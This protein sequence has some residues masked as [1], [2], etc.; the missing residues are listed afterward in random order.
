MKKKTLFWSLLASLIGLLLSVLFLPKVY[1]DGGYFDQI[2]TVLFAGIVLGLVNYFLKPA[3]SLLTAPLKIL[4]LGLFALIL[5]ILI[6]WG[7]DVLFP[8]LHIKGL[9]YL[10]LTSLIVWLANLLTPKKKS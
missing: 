10:F 5:D 8:S 1:I 3:L 9:T 7:I 2:K 6:I 4:T